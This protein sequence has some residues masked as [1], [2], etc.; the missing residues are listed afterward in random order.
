[1]TGLWQV[2]G[3]TDLS[4]EERVRLDIDYVGCRTLARDVSVCL[5]TPGVLVSRVGAY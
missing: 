3:R 1:M 5:R 4:Y 2:S